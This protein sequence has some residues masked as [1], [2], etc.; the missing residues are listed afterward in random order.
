MHALRRILGSPRTIEASLIAALAVAVLYPLMQSGYLALLDLPFG[1]RPFP[2]WTFDGTPQHLAPLW[3]LCDALYRLLPSPE[4]VGKL[5]AVA[6][7]VAI[8]AAAA[9]LGGT[10]RAGR[11]FAIGLCMVNP[12]VTDRLAV[13][14]LPLLA[15]YA[16]AMVAL[17]AVIRVVQEPSRSAAVWLGVATSATGALSPHLLYVFALICTVL[18]A[19]HLARANRTLRLA[20][21]ESV[22]IGTGV[23]VLLSAYWL[24]PLLAQP[25]PLGRF[26]EADVQ[27]FMTR[28]DPAF[29]LPFNVAAFYGFWRRA[30]LTKDWLPG[31]WLG[32]DALLLLGASGLVALWRERSTRSL[33]LG[34]A[35]AYGAVL[36]VACGIAFAPTAGAWNWAFEHVPGFAG[37]REPQKASAFL[38]IITAYAGAR[39]LTW[40]LEN[41]RPRLRS[42]V[43]ALAIGVPLVAGAGDFGGVRGALE[44]VQY[45]AVWY[46]AAAF[47]RA[48][49]QSGDAVLVLPW[50][51]YLTFEFTRGATVSNPASLFLPGSVVSSDDPQL[52]GLAPANVDERHRVLNA[53]FARPDAREQLGVTMAAL[54]IRWVFVSDLSAS[55]DGAPRLALAGRWDDVAVYE[56]TNLV[57]SAPEGSPSV[58]QRVSQV[59]GI[60]LSVISLAAVV[61]FGLRTVARRRP[62]RAES[63][64]RP[65]SI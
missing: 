8:G 25:S 57:A 55:L 15:S 38:V 52:A 50:R 32:A 4:V 29:G 44:P 43:T 20:L 14:Q 41:M 48:H 23:M 56:V 34:L 62:T 51:Q 16:A 49:E 11:L 36:I 7:L 31:W 27:A 63:A 5:L 10:S 47:L 45:P 54:G 65:P 13:G 53:L 9:P 21:I 59:A 60:A 58:A 3:L 33:S 17:R 28:G 39:G 40:L 6:V 42:M 2:V 22:C 64:A 18:F 37:L 1:P 26:G 35:A 46:S 19:V 30:A 61:C 24:V 12:W